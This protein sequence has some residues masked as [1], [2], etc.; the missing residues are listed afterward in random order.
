MSFY[1]DFIKLIHQLYRKSPFIINF[2]KS[3]D[4][5][6]NRVYVYITR[7]ANL[8]L[9]DLLDEESCKYWEERLKI[10]VTSGDIG[11]RRSAI[12]AK[13]VTK[14]KSNLSQIQEVCDSWENGEI[15]ADFVN[16]II[17]IQFVGDYGIPSDIDS[18]KIAIENVKPAHLGYKLSY[19]Y[20]LIKDIHE[21][22]TLENMGKI[23]IN[24]FAM[25]I[26]E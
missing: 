22:K 15:E 21:V 5:M 23:Q 24:N 10:N 16:G 18:L 7:I 1:D 2:T 9:F 19:K 20:L 14:A 11:I 26:E 8:Y 12:R 13:W 6:L 25:G 4:L 3:L 17:N